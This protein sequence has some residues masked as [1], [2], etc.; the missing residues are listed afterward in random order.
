[1]RHEH[2]MHRCIQ[3]AL[4]GKGFVAP[5]PLV[6]AVLVYDDII[7]GEGY[8]QQYGQA[9]AEVNCIHSVQEADKKFIP[10][11]TLYVSLEPCVHF[12][13]TPP[14]VDLIL[15]YCIAKVVIGCSDPFEIVHHKGIAK[16]KTS[17]VE[18]IV[19]VLEE[20]CK[21]INKYFFHY[22]TQ[23]RPYIMLKW[24][25][26]VDG[27]IASKNNKRTYISNDISNRLV[28]KYRS[29]MAAI[30]V[31]TR[32]ALHDN[33]S[34]TNRFWKGP[35]PARLLLDLDLK[36]PATHHLLDRTCKTIIFNHLLHK[37][38]N[39]LIWYKIERQNIPQ[40]I[41]IALYTLHIQSV[42]IEGGTQL[43][44][45]FIQNNLW[46]E[47][48]IIANTT[49]QLKEGLAAPMLNHAVRWYTDTYLQDEIQY[50]Q[51]L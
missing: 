1:M 16:L 43:L 7:I 29:E 15:K 28:H 10:L 20:Q 8:H 47:A 24:A 37:E 9:H 50:Y 27:Y 39:N 38:E 31:G 22:Y 4:L 5:N 2:Y 42:C 30:L 21:E 23:H 36:V 49:L 46:D 11:S 35:Q 25:Q 41:C 34:L 48:I 44:Q 18:V 19:G 6:G 51:P 45:S 13:K 32:T 40:Q 12:G 26:S 3:L 33:P 17:G 14:C